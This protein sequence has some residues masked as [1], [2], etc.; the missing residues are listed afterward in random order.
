MP[1]APSKT[2]S[3]Q[4]KPLPIRPIQPAPTS[5]ADDKT[6][7]ALVPNDSGRVLLAA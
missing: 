4:L 1:H 2:Q 5:Y 6:A 7:T 3:P